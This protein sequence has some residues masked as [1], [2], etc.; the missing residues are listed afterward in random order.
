MRLREWVPRPAVV[1]AAALAALV[2]Y[3]AMLIYSVPR[4][5]AGAGG[6]PMFDLRPLGY[7]HDEAIA[8]L[9]ALTPEARQFYLTV[10]HGIDTPFPILLAVATALAIAYLTRPGEPRMVAMPAGLRKFLLFVVCPLMAVFDLA[11]NSAVAAMLR[12]EPERVSESMVALAS[13]LTVAKSLT[14][15]VGLTSLLA[16]GVPFAIGKWR[17]RE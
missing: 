13:A 6:L 11:E 10:Q 4:L 9:R 3:V 8:Y 2:F 15:T 12:A 16:I 7:T 1:I 5:M 14:V 17:S